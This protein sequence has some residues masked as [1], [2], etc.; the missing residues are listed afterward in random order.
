MREN[1]C[2][3]IGIINQLLNQPIFDP[4]FMMNTNLCSSFTIGT[5]TANTPIQFQFKLLTN[6]FEIKQL[7]VTIIVIGGSVA[8]TLIY[9]SWQKYKAEKR[10]KK[11]RKV[12]NIDSSTFFD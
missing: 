5:G 6:Q 10:R 7:I 9:V 2:G 1:R 4:F 12:K 8:T 11:K 3:V